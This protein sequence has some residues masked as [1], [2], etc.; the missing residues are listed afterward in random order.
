MEAKLQNKRPKY[1]NLLKIRQPLPAVISILHRITGIL[2]FFPGI[3][4][5]LCTLQLMLGSQDSYE[6]L[7]FFLLNPVVKVGLLLLLWFFLHHLCAGIRYLAL[8][9][10]YGITLSQARAS[11]KLVLVT[12]IILTILFGLVIW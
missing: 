4:L 8:D 12:G 11:S 7:H 6:K 5:L 9:L 1:L 3:P 2:L 10:H